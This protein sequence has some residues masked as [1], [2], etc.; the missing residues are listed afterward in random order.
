MFQNVF[1]F[2]LCSIF[3]GCFFKESNSQTSPIAKLIIQSDVLEIK[4]DGFES[5]HFSV[6]GKKENGETLDLS[7]SVKYYADSSL[8]SSSFSSFISKTYH[9]WAEYS[10][11]KSNV[12]ILNTYHEENF[13]YKGV[14]I[15][16]FS[17]L[18][19]HN[20]FF[21][22][23]NK[24]NTDLIEILKN[25]GINTIRLRL[26]INNE[27]CNLE[28]TLYMAKKIKDAG[29]NFLL[30]FHYSDTWAD[31]GA[32]IKPVSWQNL[33][34]DE[35][36]EEIYKYTFNVLNQLKYQ[37]TPPQLIQIGNEINT[38][39]LK[40]DGDVLEFGWKNFSI[41]LKSAI[42]ASSDSLSNSD[43]KIIIHIAGYDSADW[44]FDNL[45]NY[46]VNFDII[47]LSYYPWWHGTN[48]DDLSTNL[49][50]ISTKFNKKIIII[51][52]AYPWTLDY[53]D[54]TNN[55]IGSS[56]N[57][58]PK[59]NPSVSGQKEYLISLLDLIKNKSLNN[60]IGLFYWAPEW[61]SFKGK[62]AQDGSSWENLTLFDFENN[63]LDSIKAF[64]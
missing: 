62:E 26:W 50:D 56:D 51:E 4:A 49:I 34:F 2:L 58:I 29:L 9:I 28:K 14:D 55:I 44:F 59:Y 39:F 60:G 15:S 37:G 52:T 25:N 18:E 20:V 63:V 40:P 6:I 41:L 32:Q 3:I 42:K 23:F 45:N 1:I 35:L 17:E 47:G 43:V 22:D 64:K 31:P 57:L 33:S 46:N 36:N 11:I 5:F 21:K 54:C 12:I 30:D 48:L 13:F 38:G 10:D 61:V 7:D 8:I 24:N 27:Y 16:F 53:N 19:D